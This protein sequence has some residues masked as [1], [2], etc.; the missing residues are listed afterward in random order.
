MYINGPK[1]QTPY[2]ATFCTEERIKPNAKKARALIDAIHETIRQRRECD[3]VSALV[4]HLE[5]DAGKRCEAAEKAMVATLIDLGMPIK[6][7]DEGY[8]HDPELAAE[9]SFDYPQYVFL[10]D[11][12]ALFVHVK[13]SGIEVVLTSRDLAVDLDQFVEDAPRG[14]LGWT[15]N[16]HSK[17]DSDTAKPVPTAS[18]LDPSIWTQVE[19]VGASL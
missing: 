3:G 12:V 10:H 1:R 14:S 4:Q 19:V 13:S 7:T 5:I 11:N 6:L 16:P 17:G 8:R 15:E 18:P 9:N 2:D